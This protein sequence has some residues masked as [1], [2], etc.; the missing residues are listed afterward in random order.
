MTKTMMQGKEQVV[1]SKLV[2]WCGEPTLQVWAYQD[3]PLEIYVQ[4][5][6]DQE[7]LMNLQKATSQW[8]YCTVEGRVGIVIPTQYQAVCF[9]VG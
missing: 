8:K 5:R 2:K 9:A 4:K 1:D 3:T 6:F 7:V